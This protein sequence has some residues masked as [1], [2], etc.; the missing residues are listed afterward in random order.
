MNKEELKT[1][2]NLDRRTLFIR[3]VPED[4]T[5]EE[6][7]EYF[8]QFVPVKH[9]VIVT[10][11]NKKSRGFGFVSFTM[12]EDTLTALVEAKKQKFKGRFLRVDI[13]KRRDRKNKNKNEEAPREERAPRETVEKRKARIIIRNLP[14]SCKTPD[15]LKN[16]FQRYGAVHDAYIPTKKGG[17]MKGF[18]FVIM[19]KNSAAER[20][21]KECVGLKIDGREVAVDLAVE[22]SKWEKLQEDEQTEIRPTGRE[23]PSKESDEDENMDDAEDEE[24]AN[25]TIH[26][27]DDEDESVEHKDFDELNGLNSDEEEEEDEHEVKREKKN[28]QEAFSVFVRNIPY[29]ADKDSLTEHFSQFGPV[30]YALPVID[31]AT[32]VSRGSAFVAFKTLEAYKDCLDNAPPVSSTSM[33]I[34][35]DVSPAYVYQGRILSIASTVDRDSASRLAERNT[36]QRKEVLGISK[37]DRDRRNLFLLN[38]GRITEH[39]KLAQFISKTDMELREKSYKLR[40][41]Q[42][43][44]NPTLHLSLTRLAIRNLPRAMTSKTLKAL[45]RKA[46]VQFATDVKEGVRQ[47]LSKEEVNRSI[48]FK[49]EDDNSGLNSE[50]KMQKQKERME[51]EKLEKEKRKNKKMGVVKQAK[52]VMELKESGE[53]GRSRGYGFIEFRDHKAALMGLRWLN[54]HEVSVDEITDGM[55][56]EEKKGVSI[57]MTNKRKLIAEFAI[58]NAQVVK[59]RKE[60][61]FLAR[62]NKRKRTEDGDEDE[63]IENSTRKDKKRKG[64][65]RKGNMNKGVKTDKKKEG[66]DEKKTESKSGVSDNVKAIIGR[67]RRDRKGK[68]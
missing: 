54:A 45:G 10:D 60:K 28:T 5:S 12:D 33:L 37:G 23:R 22:K 9:A 53:V 57:D 7:S 68:N 39:S 42:L 43:N 26:E 24:K 13:A 15:K 67:K 29:D 35:D 41:Q 56:E 20:A 66:N 2:E 58:E 11:E 31:R 38:E 50:E 19:K 64:P 61:E 3:A 55:T 46:V 51:K 14:W 65:S 36:D 4:A 44:K 59:R 1:D 32:G 40:V 34:S 16:I 49:H 8:S 52:V 18:G 63:D 25:R 21:V 47:P 30:K 6:L 17:L 27:S 48:K 62:N